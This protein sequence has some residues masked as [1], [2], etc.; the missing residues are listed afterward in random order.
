[1]AK[2]LV[3]VRRARD[4]DEAVEREFIAVAHH[5]LFSSSADP[6]LE[7]LSQL[8]AERELI[9]RTSQRKIA[10]AVVVALGVLSLLLLRQA[11][12]FGC[13]DLTVLPKWL[14]SVKMYDWL[15]RFVMI[16]N[17][18]VAIITAV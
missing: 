18:I 10:T 11:S 5:P 8:L 4:L 6:D 16:V 15:D 17:P 14:E 7:R 12:A 1:M 3:R 9:S 2:D 13:C